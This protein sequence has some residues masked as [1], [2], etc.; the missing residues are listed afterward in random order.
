MCI[1]GP[2]GPYAGS[3][4][5]DAATPDLPWERAQILTQTAADSAV[6]A[7][8]V[9]WTTSAAAAGWQLRTTTRTYAAG[10]HPAWN[11]AIPPHAICHRLYLSATRPVPDPT[12]RATL[13][14]ALLAHTAVRTPG[15]HVFLT[16][17]DAVQD[18]VF[19]TLTNRSLPALLA[20]VAEQRGQLD[21]TLSLVGPALAVG[22]LGEDQ[23]DVLL[24]HPHFAAG[25]NHTTSP[26]VRYSVDAPLRHPSCPHHSSTPV[27]LTHP[28][29][30][31]DQC[32]LVKVD[33]HFNATETTTQLC[34]RLGIHAT[35]SAVSAYDPDTDD[36]QPMLK[37]RAR[38]LADGRALLLA[39]RHSGPI[40]LPQGVMTLLRFT[41][42]RPLPT[43]TSAPL[44]GPADYLHTALVQPGR[45]GG[46]QAFQWVAE[47][48]P[49]DASGAA[50]AGPSRSATLPRFEEPW[51]GTRP[52]AVRGDLRLPGLGGCARLVA[53]PQASGQPGQAP[54]PLTLADASAAPLP[55]QG[56][57][58]PTCCPAPAGLPNITP[59]PLH[60]G[61]ALVLA[62]ASGGAVRLAGPG[63]IALIH[64]AQ[65]AWVLIQLPPGAGCVAAKQGWQDTLAVVINNAVGAYYRFA[66]PV[67]PTP[68]V[69]GAALTGPPRHPR[70]G[71]TNWPTHRTPGPTPL[72][73]RGLVPAT[74]ASPRSSP[75]SI[76][77]TPRWA[78]HRCCSR[79]FA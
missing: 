71:P 43:G 41:Y 58:H 38:T 6:T 40:T 59:D 30:G 78:S 13:H 56:P 75:L 34:G 16:P 70:H 52:L 18:A 29:H 15:H 7:T 22:N 10:H 66:R 46:L 50:L 54:Q 45:V 39:A 14:A 60:P 3:P 63:E 74:T 67:P 28:A 51:P 65:P 20:A 55:W 76:A 2:S 42:T 61:E 48:T 77:T 27:H 25:V 23:V 36:F 8:L 35:G 12:W 4:H 79:S 11:A 31:Q 5:I 73:P 68:P 49:A 69:L 64:I 47:R 21:L 17:S 19:L 24:Q 1:H 72:R 26:P 53:W 62:V 44:L 37:L 33:R 9:A 57:D 32:W